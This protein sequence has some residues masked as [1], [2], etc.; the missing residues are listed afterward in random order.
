MC[1]R[2]ALGPLFGRPYGGTSVL[3]RNELLT[4]AECICC[5]ARYVVVRVG[6]L[7]IANVYL[8]CVGTPERL[9]IV[10]DVL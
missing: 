7:I 6:S 5:A 9:Y 8:P 2:V 10:E 1:D 3:I 4:A